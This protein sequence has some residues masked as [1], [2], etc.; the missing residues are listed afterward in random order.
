MPA[1]LRGNSFPTEKLFRRDCENY[2][3]EG[4]V[5][6]MAMTNQLE[7]PALGAMAVSQVEQQKVILGLRPFRPMEFHFEPSHTLL[8]REW[9]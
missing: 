2:A 5:E 1:M 3:R 4:F 6:V 8:A 9:L 7:K